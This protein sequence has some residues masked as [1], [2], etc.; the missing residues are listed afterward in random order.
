MIELLVVIA[1]IA[2]LAGL[3]LPS[4]AKA[5]NQANRTRCINNNKQ[6]ML[7]SIMYSGDN[8]EY[9]PY[10]GWGNNPPVNWA[11]EVLNRKRPEMRTRYDVEGGQLWPYIGTPDVYRCSMERS[12]QTYFKL[13]V[14][15]G[16]QDVTSYV[17]NGSV[18]AYGTGVN[19]RPGLTFKTTDFRPDDVILWETD[20][21]DPFFFNDPS[22]RPDEGISRRH[23]EGAVVALAGGSTE[24]MKWVNW[25]AEAGIPGTRQRGNR[26]GRLWNNPQAPKDGF[27]N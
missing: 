19:G 26:P 22:S 10:P 17:M 3:L 7:A 21:T 8:E 15:S 11:F 14:S 4:L 20:E 13:R 6:L 9:M 1:I 2:I 18:S 24:F 23:N 12:N 25:Y 5:K 27:R 16:Y